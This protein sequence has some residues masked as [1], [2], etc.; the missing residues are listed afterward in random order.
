[1]SKKIVIANEKYIS[2][3]TAQGLVA[4]TP[5]QYILDNQE[6]KSKTKVFNLSSNMGYQEKG[7]YVSLLAM[8]R[9]DKVLPSAR[10]IQD[11]N[12]RKINKIISEE[13][14]NLAQKKLKKL[15]SQ[16]FELSVYFGKNVATA[17]DK[18]AWELFRIIQAP[19]FRVYF[20][21]IGQWQ[22][23]KISLLTLETI[24]PKHLDFLAKTAKDYIDSNKY[25]KSKSHRYHYDMAILYNEKE[26]NPPSD[27]RALKKFVK[28]FERHHF[29]VRLIQNEERPD[30]NNFDALFI[31]ETTNVTHHTYRI[32]R[33]ADIEGVV[34]MD[35][36]DSIVRCTNKIFL[37][38]LVE[39]LKV[40]RP[41]SIITDSKSLN[42]HLDSLKF[43][44]IVKQPD[45]AFSQ[46]VHKA[47]CMEEF[48]KLMA[49]LFKTSELLIVQEYIPTDYDWRIGVLD[50]EIIYACK[51]FMAKDH[52]QIINHKNGKNIE[53]DYESIDPKDVDEKIKKVSLKVA[54]EI[55]NGL[56]GVDLKQK[57]DQVYFI[58]INDNPN[59]DAG[60]EDK[61]LGDE[62][63]DKIAKYFYNK[64]QNRKGQNVS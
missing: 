54:K 55:G 12:N 57:D 36:P 13:I 47:T 37:E 41:K 22:I 1:M 48:K 52:W 21:N 31:R 60:V 15:K 62:L 46:G 10:T 18:L 23:K 63:Y 27:K 26:A 8:A 38:Q 17:Y 49:E 39:R 24:D 64:C 7:Y 33:S 56:Y 5:M 53:G 61:L 25:S 40:N 45:S 42:L 34:V 11:L 20:E 32:S 14:T 19:M 44:C 58:E 51:Y 30:V 4:K 50:G 6:D 29:R 35:D 16:N 59:I 2:Q 28:A 3:F 9:G 43:P